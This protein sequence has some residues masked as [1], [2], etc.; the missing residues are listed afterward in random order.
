MRVDFFFTGCAGPF[1]PGGI[2]VFAVLA[3]YDDKIFWRDSGLAEH[4]RPATTAIARYAGACCA[5]RK[6]RE[7]HDQY[8]RTTF[9]LTTDRRDCIR[10]LRREVALHSP[11]SYASIFDQASSLLDPVREIATLRWAY[12][13]DPG[14]AAVRKIAQQLLLKHLGGFDMSQ[15]RRGANDTTRGN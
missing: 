14:I 7:V 10:E 3:K 11:V 6:L 2:G 4:G 12:Q 15:K 9:T 1:T 5:L 8:P 13:Q